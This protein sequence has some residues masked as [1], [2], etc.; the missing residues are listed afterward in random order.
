MPPMFVHSDSSGPR[1][2]SPILISYLIPGKIRISTLP[3]S[4]LAA[5]ISVA[6]YLPSHPALLFG[7][8]LTSS[9]LMFPFSSHV[10]IQSV[11]PANFALWSF[12]R[13]TMYIHPSHGVPGPPEKPKPD[14]TIPHSNLNDL[15]TFPF[16]SLTFRSS[17]GT[18]PEA[19]H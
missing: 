8:F 11:I 17:P 6:L 14:R 10:S 5:G 4:L 16:L 13:L 12:Q 9:S 18:M 2:R 1:G 3:L 7:T 15:S 19:A